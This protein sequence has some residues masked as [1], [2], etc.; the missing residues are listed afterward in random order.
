M[1]AQGLRPASSRR[2]FFRSRRRHAYRI[3]KRSIRRPPT[4]DLP[5]RLRRGRWSW[6]NCMPLL[7]RLPQATLDVSTWFDTSLCVL[8]LIGSFR[9]LA[10]ISPHGRS[11]NATSRSAKATLGT[12]NRPRPPSGGPF[13]VA[14]THSK[15]RM[16]AGM[17]IEI[18]S[19]VAC[20]APVLASMA[21]TTRLLPGMLAHISQ[22]PSGVISRF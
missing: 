2:E 11:R 15:Q 22:R 12:T 18:G 8:A 1:R 4:W 20:R 13:P 17:G 21:K 7:R 3:R 14:S 10:L 9:L 5:T 16:Q 6:K 19:A